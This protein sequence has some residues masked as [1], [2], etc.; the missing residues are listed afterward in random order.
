MKNKKITGLNEKY[1][2]E[3]NKLIFPTPVWVYRLGS[4]FYCS[5]KCWI[6]NDGSRIN[7]R[8]RRK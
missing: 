5:Y 6:K 7:G 2:A 1:C 8:K 4:K 3:C